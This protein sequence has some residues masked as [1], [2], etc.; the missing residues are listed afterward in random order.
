MIETK[1]Q[2][3]GGKRE[4]RRPRIRI[5]C[6]DPEDRGHE[7]DELDSTRL[8]P[9]LAVFEAA[10]CWRRAPDYLKTELQSELADATDRAVLQLA[11]GVLAPFNVD[12]LGAACRG[13]R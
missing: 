12:L 10:V 9:L 2:E 8:L 7:W 6:S 5:Q 11:Q 13:A 1:G 3:E 4:L